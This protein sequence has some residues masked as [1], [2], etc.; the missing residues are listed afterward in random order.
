[1][2]DKLGFPPERRRFSAHVTLCRL[3][4]DTD[5]RMALVELSRTPVDVRWTV[6]ELV[7]FESTGA[8][9]SGRY[10]PLAVARLGGAVR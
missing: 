2:L 4:E 9:G 10:V 5:V 1:V 3:E 6:D 8:T 7:L